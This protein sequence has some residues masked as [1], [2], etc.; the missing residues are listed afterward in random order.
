MSK[1]RGRP[2]RTGKEQDETTQEQTPE[3]ALEFASEPDFAEEHTEPTFADEQR[4][5]PE[6]VPE[7]E[8]PKGYGGM[9]FSSG[10]HHR[11]GEDRT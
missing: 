3:E 5:G 6:G 4:G 8:S 2:E 9:D 7:P 11:H 1:L 10:T